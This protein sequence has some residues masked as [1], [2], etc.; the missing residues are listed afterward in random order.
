MIGPVR[1]SCRQKS[2]PDLGGPARSSLTGLT[3]TLVVVTSSAGGGCFF[4]P[5]VESGDPPLTRTRSTCRCGPSLFRSAHIL[6]TTSFLQKVEKVMEEGQGEEEKG[7]GGG[8]N[9]HD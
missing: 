6:T 3:D 1:N 4:R 5:P 9:A 8:R 7:R 2:G